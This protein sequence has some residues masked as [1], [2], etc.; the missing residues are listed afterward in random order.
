VA[1]SGG[2]QP[3]VTVTVAG[4]NPATGSDSGTANL[5]DGFLDQMPGEV[6][7]EDGA[8]LDLSL[9]TEP[10]GPKPPDELLARLDEDPR[11]AGIRTLSSTQVAERVREASDV[12]IDPAVTPP[13]VLVDLVDP[14]RDE[15]DVR[16]EMTDESNT[17]TIEPY[18][19]VVIQADIGRTHWIPGVLAAPTQ[20]GVVDRTLGFVELVFAG[21]LWF[22]RGPAPWHFVTVPDE[23]AGTIEAVAGLASY[24][25]GMIPVKATVGATTFSTSLWPRGDTY[26]VP[27]KAAVRKAERS[28]SAT[29]STSGSSSTSDPVATTPRTAVLGSGGGPDGT[30]PSALDLPS[31]TLLTR[32]FT[33]HGG[34]PNRKPQP[35]AEVPR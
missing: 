28:S 17:E 8:S 33:R 11:V 35:T 30:A 1:R 7:C 5:V 23:E 15:A 29:R 21:E 6:P 13:V 22:W 10:P 9:C 18:R 19:S 25:W 3:D 27:F 31:A 32:A 34:L 24:G 4:S 20:G 16:D 26:I 2:D 12:V 14:G